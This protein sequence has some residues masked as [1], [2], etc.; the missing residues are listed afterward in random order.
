MA[1]KAPKSADIDYRVFIVGNE[2][3]GQ[4]KTLVSALLASLWR[5]RFPDFVLAAA[6]TM[7][8]SG[9]ASKFGRWL[10]GVADFGTGP[11]TDMIQADREAALAYWERVGDLLISKRR[12]DG[13][14]LIDLGANVI[15]AVFEWAKSNAV[16]EM[17]DPTTSIELVLP[18]TAASTSLKDARSVLGYL[19][20]GCI[21]VGKVFLVENEFLGSFSDVEALPDYK[22]VRGFAERSGGG[23][24][25]LPRCD[26]KALGLFEQAHVNLVEGRAMD[27]RDILKMAPK[28][29]GFAATRWSK[30]YAEWFDACVSSF[31]KVGLL[32]GGVTGGVAGESGAKAVSG[33]SIEDKAP[34]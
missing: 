11:R 25:R 4:G 16:P 1:P 20:A 18:V 14:A 24:V 21:P 26:S 17:F 7:D 13:G 27:F 32:P 31:E 3:G 9:M 28:T 33:A 19:D 12:G 30:G 2:T 6:D 8:D 22:F 29:T 10:P 23:C 34:L 15:G 5:E